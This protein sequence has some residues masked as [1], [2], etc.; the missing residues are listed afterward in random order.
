MFSVW[1]WGYAVIIV[2]ADFLVSVMMIM[3][4]Q[5]STKQ[6]VSQKSWYLSDLILILMDRN[7]EILSHGTKMVS[8]NAVFV[9][10]FTEM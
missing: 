7:S 4:W 1:K 2:M 8:A 10:Y 9:L 6:P 3:I 5:P